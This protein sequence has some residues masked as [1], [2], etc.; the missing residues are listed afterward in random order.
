MSRRNPHRF[1][2]AI[3]EPPINMT[4]LIDVVF[5]ILI[6]FIVVAPLLDVD[7]IELAGSH[8]HREQVMPIQDQ[9][10][11]TIRVYH[12]NTV[13]FNG[14]KVLLPQLTSLLMTSK[15]TYPGARPQVFHD[16]R[17]TFGT[18]QT[19][20]NAVETAGFEEMDIVL[21]PG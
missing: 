18:Y 15:K 1:E 11:I 9:N 6:M 17:A 21:S 5:V 10:P 16:K 7:R 20:K 3:E 14:Q 8:S 12:D 2:T 19:V 13:K 4:P